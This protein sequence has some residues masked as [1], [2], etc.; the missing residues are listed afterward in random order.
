MND[1]F[2]LFWSGN[3]FLFQCEWLLGE[4]KTS[5]QDLDEG[6]D[7]NGAV[8]KAI[9]ANPQVQLGLNN[10]RCLL[11]RMCFS[12]V[13]ILAFITA[14]QLIGP[15]PN[16]WNFNV[17]HKTCNGDCLLTFC[18]QLLT[19][20]LMQFVTYFQLSYKCLTVPWQHSS[21]YLTLILVHF[22]CRCP[23]SIMQKNMLRCDIIAPF[24][25]L[26][27]ID[28]FNCGHL[29]WYHFMLVWSVLI[30]PCA[31]FEALVFICAINV[32]KKNT[33]IYMWMLWYIILLLKNLTEQEFCLWFWCFDFF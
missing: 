3:C 1:K 5:S 15:S 4:K 23:G 25:L 32:V 20:W 10:P 29:L 2:W 19:F 26:L 31:A 11:G 7:T 21:G 17:Q 27:N 9:M 28:I 8:Y 6:L 16:I 14:E 18:I 22:W 12:N 13:I 24:H 33:F 30:F